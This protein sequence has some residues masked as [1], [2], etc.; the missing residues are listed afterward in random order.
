MMNVFGT[1]DN[2]YHIPFASD[3]CQKSKHLFSFAEHKAKKNWVV[4]NSHR[5]YWVPQ[6]NLW[7]AN[8]Y[9]YTIDTQKDEYFR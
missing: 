3:Y 5:G 2:E 4:L 9:Y 1:I 8:I 7:L 6:T